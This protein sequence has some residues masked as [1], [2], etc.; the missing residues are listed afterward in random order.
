MTETPA[1]RADR[2]DRMLENCRTR[3]RVSLSHLE[4]ARND[5]RDVATEY[6]ALE[7]E[8]EQLH[9]NGLPMNPFGEWLDGQMREQD[10]GAADVD[11][12]SNHLLAA[13][14]VMMW[15][16][17]WKAPDAGEAF[18]LANA[19]G[20]PVIDALT[21]AGHGHLVVA[22]VEENDELRAANEPAIGG[23]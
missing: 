9:A 23:E 13:G 5:L 3:G 11:D 15:R 12:R 7:A 17:G 6:E 20:V 1:Q 4:S 18:I 2:I 22:I 14:K 8:Y 16:S 21:A 19:L 10:L